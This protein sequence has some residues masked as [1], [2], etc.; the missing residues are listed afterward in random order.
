MP[1]IHLDAPKPPQF[2]S[3]RLNG[4][5][6]GKLM[7]TS[8]A[9]LRDLE[10]TGADFKDFQVGW[11]KP[12]ISYRGDEAS[13]S[14]ETDSEIWHYLDEGTDI[15][16][17]IMNDP[18]QSKTSVGVLPSRPGQRTYNKA[19]EYTAIRGRRAMTARNIPPAPGIEARGWTKLIL[20]KYGQ[21][22]YNDI[23]RI[24]TEELGG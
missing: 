8:R 12:V 4:R 3:R 2:I 14:I 21:A 5:L 17:A 22:F 11:E 19:G 6:L 7:S 20:A 24:V 23:V 10:S 15:R 1:T 13:I 18:F 9:I 16:W